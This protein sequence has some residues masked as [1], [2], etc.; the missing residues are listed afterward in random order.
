MNHKLCT[1]CMLEKPAEAF[2]K[3]AR[4]KSGL[5]SQC[6]SCVKIRDSMRWRENNPKKP[7][8]EKSRSTPIYRKCSV[9]NVDLHITEFAQDRSRRCGYGYI[10]KECRSTGK[11]IGRPKAKKDR[12]MI[13]QLK[14]KSTLRTRIYRS[15]KCQ[16]ASKHKKTQE[17]LGC[18]FEFFKGY[19]EAQFKVGMTWDNHGV[20]GWHIDHIYPCSAFD[21]S[22]PEEQMK[23]FHY[24]N[25]QPLWANENIL[26]GD[27]VK[28]NQPQ[29]LALTYE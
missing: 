23:C 7:L 9:C 19:L 2:H 15:L 12:D 25:M 3:D 4:I 11:P 1:Q 13:Y 6:K 24:S 14:L 10:C 21:L 26:K 28:V 27:K 8:A 5:K 18:S 22:K 16:D 29:P 17:M 20:N